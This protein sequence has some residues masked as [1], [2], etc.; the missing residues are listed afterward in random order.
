MRRAMGK[1]KR[2]EMEKH[3]AKFIEGAVAR[4][5]KREK[6]QQIFSLMAQ[7]ADYGFNRSH[8]VAYAYLAFQTAYLKAHYP[9][10][11]YAAVLT[12]ELDDTSKV[13]KYVQELKSQKIKLLPPDINESDAGFTPVKGGIRYGLEALKG[14]GH[15]SVEAILEARAEGKFLSFFDFSERVGHRALNRRVLESLVCAGAFDSFGAGRLESE[16]WRARLSAAI[17]GALHR[18]TRAQKAREVGQN[19]LFGEVQSVSAEPQFDELPAA[20][21]WTKTE[22]LSGEKN[23]IGFYITGHPL[24]SYTDLL[25]KLKCTETAYLAEAGAGKVVNV[26]G[27]VTEAQVRSTK[28][29]DRFGL[30]RLEDQHGGVKCV[31]WPEVHGKYGKLI[32]DDQAVVVTG[33]L[34]VSDD[35]LCTLY[36]SEIILLEEAVQKRARTMVVR[37]PSGL[38]ED[39][40][41]DGIWQ[42]LQASKGECEVLFE[43]L[44]D[45]VL[46]RT[47]SH[48]T[49][50][51][52]GGLQLETKLRESGCYVDWVR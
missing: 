40:K 6:A 23:A 15:S 20:A 1:K 19:A 42:V 33:R 22:L 48:S 34:E 10:H 37:L 17:D 11:F 9:E 21:A 29:G 16:D 46:V 49:L 12:N 52:A 8:S 28:K 3:E 43:M 35:N 44:L 13:F 24:E 5:I 47:K 2:E 27:V 32:V 45:G 50:R 41:L 30:F 38:C 26:G 36:A 31:A 39:A 18:G 7:F 14:V 4:N 51:V 25:A